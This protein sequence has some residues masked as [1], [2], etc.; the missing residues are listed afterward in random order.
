LLSTAGTP[1]VEAQATRPTP[2][3]GDQWVSHQMNQPPPDTSDKNALSPD[4]I[5]DIRQL[6][7]QAK[8]EAEAKT[9]DKK[10]V[11]PKAPA[12]DK[13]KP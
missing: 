7:L 11:S 5:D 1:P 10:S 2:A 9:G 4:A 6:Y 12:K 3:G 8:Q 13:A